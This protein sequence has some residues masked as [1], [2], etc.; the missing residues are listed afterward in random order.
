VRE[1]KQGTVGRPLP[2]VG[3]H[4]AGDGEILTR[5][6][7]VMVGYLKDPEQTRDAIDEDGWLHTGDI[8]ELDEEGYLRLIDRKKELIITA[9]GKNISPANIEALLRANPLFGQAVALGEARRHICAL[10]VLD[11]MAAPEWAQARGIEFASFD[12]LARHP[13]MQAEAEQTVTRTN[14]QLSRV[15]QVKHFKVLGGPWLPDS[16]ELT[17]LMK[18]KRRNILTKYAGDIEQLYAQ[19]AGQM[20]P[21]PSS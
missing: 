7:A 4:L 10:L 16:E 17:A 12:E 9:G 5:S 1:P 3:L 11:P 18:L 6:E 15:E 21:A 13:E 8:G 20:Q 19:A 14:E 2:G